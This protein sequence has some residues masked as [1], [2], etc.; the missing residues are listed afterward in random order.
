MH[1]IPAET[2]SSEETAP[3]EE[4]KAAKRPR[5]AAHRAHVAPSKAKSG[6]KASPAKKATKGRESARSPKKATGF[7]P[8]RPP[9]PR[10]YE[11]AARQSPAP[12]C[13]RILRRFL[14]SATICPHLGVE[15]AP[16]ADPP[17]M[18]IPINAPEP[19]SHL[20]RCF[21]RPLCGPLV[22]SPQ[23]SAGRRRALPVGR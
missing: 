17:P 11:R 15:F 20:T 5:A 2:A 13:G 1:G 6:K 18:W 19:E 23:T 8:R 12:S 7:L 9:P 22:R 21:M 10:F 4:P 14:T 16:T 3:A